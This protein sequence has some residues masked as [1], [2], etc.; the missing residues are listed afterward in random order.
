MRTTDCTAEAF[1]YTM[2]ISTISIPSLLETLMRMVLRAL[3]TTSGYTVM[4]T[5]LWGRYT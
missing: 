1:A 2:M 3:A 5:P 4:M